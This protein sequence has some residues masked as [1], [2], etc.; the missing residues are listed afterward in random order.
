MRILTLLSMSEN[1]E[2]LEPL[3]EEDKALAVVIVEADII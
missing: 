3:R 1:D 2:G